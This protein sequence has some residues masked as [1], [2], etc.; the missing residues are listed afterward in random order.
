MPAIVA[1]RRVQTRADGSCE[2]SDAVV[3]AN[4]RAAPSVDTATSVAADDSR[5]SRNSA[6]APIG[7][8]PDRIDGVDRAH[9]WIEIS[10]RCRSLRS[11]SSRARWA[12]TGR[13]APASLT[14]RAADSD[15]T[16][17]VANA[18]RA[19]TV[20]RAEAARPGPNSVAASPDNTLVHEK[21][22]GGK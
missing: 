6:Q 16:S 4:Q 17:A 14:V 13:V 15:D 8:T 2:M 21:N 5:P 18:A 3:H 19:A 10:R 22:S 11:R 9:T 20:R 1:V 7:S 12:S